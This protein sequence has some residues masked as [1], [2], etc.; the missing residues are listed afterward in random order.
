MEKIN[1]SKFL[2]AFNF[3][4]YCQEYRV[5]LW[6]CPPFIFTIMGVIIIAA[7]LTTYLI[8]RIYAEPIMVVLITCVLTAVLF[9]LSYI[10]LASFEQMAKSSKEKSEF[11]SIMSHQLRNPLSSIK[12]QLDLLRHKNEQLLAIEEQN[13][14]MIHLINDLLEVSR[15]EDKTMI[16]K[17]STFSIIDLFKETI[18]KYTEHAT[19]SNVEIVFLPT[20]E[21][22]KIFADKEKI[23]VA[24]THLLDN[25]IRYSP[26]GGRVE[27]SLERSN[28]NLRCSITDEGVGVPEKEKENIFKKFF[29]G[30]ESKKYKSDGLGI[31]LYI[32]KAIVEA[33][34]GETGFSSIEGKGSTFWFT[35]PLKNKFKNLL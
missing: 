28:N 2:Q 27:I 9:V 20:K 34:K 3:K 6:Q 33:F 10:I 24:I 5:D 8:G 1:F 14:R 31:G 7:I 18:A 13:E 29:R 35:L 23:R 19:F 21:D 17:S 25:A 22:L 32:V 12:W 26:N 15:F 4:K 11:I 16:V 30:S